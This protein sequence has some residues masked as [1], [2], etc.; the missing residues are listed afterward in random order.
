LGAKVRAIKSVAPPGGK[1]TTKVTGLSG[2]AYAAPMNKALVSMAKSKWRFFI[3][4]LLIGICV[5]FGA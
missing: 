3:L 5:M 4:C 2:Q 1:G